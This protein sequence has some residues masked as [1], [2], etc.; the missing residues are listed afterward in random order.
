MGMHPVVR[1]IT[2]CRARSTN[3]R[4]GLRKAVTRP[5]DQPK[6]FIYGPII[7][8]EWN[9]RCPTCGSHD[10][11]YSGDIATCYPAGHAT[12]R[13]PKKEARRR[14]LSRWRSVGSSHVLGDVRDA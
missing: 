14:A 3:A 10:W 13:Y 7:Y 2:S 6:P 11:I 5:D 1:S 12:A 9:R 4:V 8:E